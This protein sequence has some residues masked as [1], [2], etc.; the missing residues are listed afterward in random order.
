MKKKESLKLDP[1]K[2]SILHLPDE[3]IVLILL[4]GID[5]VTL[6]RIRL[7]SK[8]F[9]T[10][11]DDYKIIQFLI[12]KLLPIFSPHL[13]IIELENLRVGSFHLAKIKETFFLVLKTL[14]SGIFLVNLKNLEC[15]SL[16]KDSNLKLTSLLILDIEE[17]NFFITDYANGNIAILSILTENSG[18]ILIVP[19]KTLYA[20]NQ[21]ING[22]EYYQFQDKHMLFSCS[23]DK[24][25]KVWDINNGRCL[26]TF[27]NHQ[28]SVSCIKIISLQEKPVIISGSFDM[29]VSILD[30]DTKN[31]I[32]TLTG[33]KGPITCLETIKLNTINTLITSSYDSTI[34]LWN[35]YKKE[36]FYIIN[37]SPIGFINCFQILDVFNEKF[38][39]SLS[40]SIQVWDLKDF[41]LIKTLK[42]NSDGLAKIGNI[43]YP[44][45][46]T[47][48]K[49][50]FLLWNFIPD[51]FLRKLNKNR[52][53]GKSI[54]QAKPLFFNNEQKPF[55]NSLSIESKNLSL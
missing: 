24:S 13:N 37:I 54:G 29:T 4:S 26:H 45:L 42:N 18:N 12:P 46:I 49:K 44:F 41:S 31:I 50:K 30:L 9:N 14:N 16:A 47:S 27:F 52:L 51:F 40:T 1:E 11:F 38:L 15:T 3:L 2:K 34:R 39:I 17:K 33:H 48:R 28:D 25:I 10:L 5:I 22:L 35:I 23:D 6:L 21:A 43:D 36:T 20:H 55:T 19:E 8:K 7:V 32:A 53:P